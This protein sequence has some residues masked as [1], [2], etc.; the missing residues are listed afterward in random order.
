MGALFAPRGARGHA[1]EAEEAKA[2]SAR[3]RNLAGTRRLHLGPQ[4]PAGRPLATRISWELLFPG[5]HNCG[6]RLRGEYRTRRAELLQ[7]TVRSFAPTRLTLGGGSECREARPVRPRR[8]GLPGLVVG[9]EPQGEWVGRPFRRR[10]GGRRRRGRREREAP[11]PLRSAPLSPLRC[12][13]ASAGAAGAALARRRRRRPHLPASRAAA[14]GPWASWPMAL[15]PGRGGRTGGPE[16]QRR[17]AVQTA[18]APGRRRGPGG[19][20]LG[21]RSPGLGP[22]RSERETPLGTGPLR[23]HSGLGAPARGPHPGHFKRTQV[24]PEAR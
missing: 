24:A 8:S 13:R 10:A 5:G 11:T 1:G 19:G 21:A 14:P 2:M 16:V 17:A 9:R 23:K 6:L 7:K 15:A 12:S 20:G 22:R 4:R 18:G 3:Q